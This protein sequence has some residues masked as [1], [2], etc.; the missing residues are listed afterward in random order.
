[1]EG[2][3][4]EKENV[5][6]FIKNQTSLSDPKKIVTNIQQCIKENQNAPFFL[7]A[8][9]PFISDLKIIRNDRDSIYS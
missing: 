4:G 9:L 1:M 5:E 2:I 7:A 6:K 8:L 3:E